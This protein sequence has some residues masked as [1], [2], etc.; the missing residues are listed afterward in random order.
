MNFANICTTSMNCEYLTLIAST[1]RANIN[2]VISRL[3]VPVPGMSVEDYGASLQASLVLVDAFEYLFFRGF[4]RLLRVMV[5]EDVACLV[6]GEEDTG[7]SSCRDARGFSISFAGS[8]EHAPSS[9]VLEA[10]TSAEDPHHV[11]IRV[12]ASIGPG[13]EAGWEELGPEMAERIVRRVISYAKRTR[14]YT[15]LEEVLAETEGVYELSL[16]P[17]DRVGEGVPEAALEAFVAGIPGFVLP[18]DLNPVL[19]LSEYVSRRLSRELEK[20]RE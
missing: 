2:D 17:G 8:G 9:L 6:E 11:G 13:G 19:D 4:R 20:M 16:E 18:F 5:P 14:L 12:Y 3:P 1:L 10:Q 7:V 15:G